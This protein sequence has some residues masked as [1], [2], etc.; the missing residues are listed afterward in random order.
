M[1][2]LW[3]VAK[4]TFLDAV[5]SKVLYGIAFLA[6]LMFGANILISG[7]VMREVGKVSVDIGLA[8]TGFSGLLLL[9]FVTINQLAADFDQKT[10]YM[11]LARPISRTQYLLG[12]YF[13]MVLLITVAML[14]FSA[15]MLSTISFVYWSASDY[16]DRISW[17]LV[18][19]ATLLNFCQLYILC[20]LSFLFATFS[21]SSFVTFVLTLL[22]YFIGHGLAAVKDIVASSSAIG[23]EVSLTT[24][25]IIDAAVWVFPNLSLTDI[26]LE[27]AHG[28]WP[29]TSY[30]LGTALYT[31]V[32][33]ALVLGLAVLIFRRREFS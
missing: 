9:F 23:I 20:A 24:R 2:K 18:C 10:I 8:A 27:A 25:E 33:I 12:K 26:R 11:V 31:G 13:G 17:G 19:V 5:R 22:C 30:L 1:R 7:M 6:L 4:I 28:I 16:F 29:G 32:Y 3:P 14:C 15:V 21:S